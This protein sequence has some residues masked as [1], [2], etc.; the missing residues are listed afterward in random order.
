MINVTLPKRGSDDWGSG[1][2]GASRGNR[3]HKGID[4]ECPVKALLHSPVDGE[5]TKLGYPYA[6]D[7]SYRYIE[8]TDKE[9]YRHRLFYVEPYVTYEQQIEEGDFI[10]VVQD[11]AG[12]YNKQGKGTMK[13]HVHYEILTQ[14]GIPVNPEEF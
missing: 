10:G 5:I 12:K 13:N 8:I 11:V 9:G 7:M 1:E 6:D 14:A 2:Y 4:Y 3:T